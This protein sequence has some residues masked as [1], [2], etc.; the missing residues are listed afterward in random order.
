MGDERL[1]GLA[2]MYTHKDMNIDCENN[3]KNIIDRF[4]FEKWL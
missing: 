3:I 2:M 4:S 1:T